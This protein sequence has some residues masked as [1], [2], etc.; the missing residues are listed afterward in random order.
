MMLIAGGSQFLLSCGRVHDIDREQRYQCV[1]VCMLE[2][3][4]YRCVHASRVRFL[5]SIALWH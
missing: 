5:T 3:P 1:Y 4:R 2:V